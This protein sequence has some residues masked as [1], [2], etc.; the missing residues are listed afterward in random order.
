MPPG[1]PLRPVQAIDK[2]PGGAFLTLS[3]GH[4]Q[5]NGGFTREQEEAIIRYSAHAFC[6]E[7]PCYKPQRPMGD[8]C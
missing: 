1:C 5:W 7:G 3:C 6:L 8:Q 4:R 2:A